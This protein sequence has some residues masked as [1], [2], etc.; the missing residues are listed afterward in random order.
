MKSHVSKGP[1][2]A[3]CRMCHGMGVVQAKK[4]GLPGNTT[5]RICPQ[6]DGSGRVTVSAKIELDIRPYIPII[7]SEL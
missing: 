4:G 1:K 5:E 7:E 3:L 6:C 2:I